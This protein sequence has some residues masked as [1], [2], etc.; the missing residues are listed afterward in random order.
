MLLLVDGGVLFLD[1]YVY[2]D[3]V[4][5]LVVKLFWLIMMLFKVV[6]W[7]DWVL[8]VGYIDGGDVFVCGSLVDWLFCYNEGCFEV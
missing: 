8:V 1:I 5:V 3:Y 4:D 6:L 7:F 2:V